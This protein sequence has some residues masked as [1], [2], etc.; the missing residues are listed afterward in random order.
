MDE[1]LTVKSV[2]MFS[3]DT[4]IKSSIKIVFRNIY[5]EVDYEGRFHYSLV[6]HISIN[7]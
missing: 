1:L 7:F 5:M 4:S 2:S 3:I 6:D